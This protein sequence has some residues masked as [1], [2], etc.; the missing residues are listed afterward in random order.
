MWTSPSASFS[1]TRSTR[2][3]ERIPNIWAYSS[4]SCTCPLSRQPLKSRMSHLDGG[5]TYSYV[6]TVIPFEMI[7]SSGFTIMG[8]EIAG[9]VDQMTRDASFVEG[10]NAGIF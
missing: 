3:G 7:K 6:D 5:Y 4:L 1:S 9:N 8:F 2:Q 10:N